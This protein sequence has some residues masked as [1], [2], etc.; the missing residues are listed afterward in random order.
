MPTH[1]LA[2]TTVRPRGISRTLAA[3]GLALATLLGAGAAQA[4]ACT[5]TTVLYAAPAAVGSADASNWA[6]A[7]TLQGA[8]ATANGNTAAGQCFEIRAKQGV[9]KPTA[10]ADRTI[11][12]AITR[13]LQLKGGYTGTSDTDRVLNAR[14]T[15]LS[16][17]IDSN[18]ADLSG[19]ITPTAADI[20]GS[21]SYH[22]MTIGG[23]GAT[24]TGGPY[25]ATASDASYTLIEG[26][27]ITGGKASGASYPQNSGGGLYCNGW[28]TGSICSPHIRQASFSGNSADYGG[29]ILN[30][31]SDSGTS[32]PTIS[33]TTFSGNS[34][35]YYGGAIYNYGLS[36]GI[37]SPAISHTTF[38]GNGANNGGAIFNNGGYS[39]TSSPTISQTTFSGNWASIDGGAIY[40]F[41]PSGTSSPAI[42]ASILWGNTGGAGPQIYNE[43]PATSSI[44]WSI[45]QDTVGWTNAPGSHNL[46]GTAPV[47]PATAWGNDPQLGPL[48]DNGGPTFT[49]LPGAGSAAIDAVACNVTGT[50]VTED[51]RGVARPQ[52]GQCDIGAVEG[53]QAAFAVTATPSPATGGSVG[54]S[55]GLVLSGGTSTC[56]ASGPNPG[57]TFSGFTGC[58][59][60]SG[61]VCTLSNVTAARSV[62]ANYT[63]ATS[64]SGTTVPSAGGTAGAASASFTGGG[65]TCA[66]DGASTGFVAAPATLPAGQTMPQGMFQFK[67]VGCMPGAT[68]QMSVTWPQPVQGLTKWGKATSAG[69]PNTH[70]APS[71]LAVTGGNTT[72][73]TVTDGQKGDDDWAQNGTIV[74][75]V[76]PVMAAGPGPGPGPGPGGPQAI[77]TLGE[78]SLALLSLLA[79]AMGM[80]ALRRRGVLRV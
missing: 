11:S 56:T 66:F 74:D 39:G 69:D 65:A 78:W 43:A 64:F 47:A 24:G 44:T 76:G 12:F 7:N 63:A 71:N 41:G 51:Q 50:T 38:S 72:T 79:V 21:N 19:G 9:Y 61:S 17:D 60:V 59:S 70:F 73:F 53:S 2:T 37:S 62:V 26:L 55:P 30:N 36:S 52:G 57:F 18:D 35:S 3:T 32:S 28:D 80:G 6:N 67:L 29:A 22:V 20:Q 13:P 49:L 14:N 4:A 40:N 75:P 10:T 34:A 23:T 77:P 16:G 42:K 15:V 48:Q 25:S 45:V 5:S 33:H 58:D 1:P 31:G 27:S 8:L 54:C 68:V 46:I